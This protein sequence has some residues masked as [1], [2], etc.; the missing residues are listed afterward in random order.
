MC[1]IWIA[2]SHPRYLE[3]KGI[4]V[5]NT[6]SLKEP[7]SYNMFDLALRRLIQM[8]NI[9]YMACN[10]KRWRHSLESDFA[11]WGHFFFLKFHYIGKLV[12]T[13]N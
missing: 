12:L 11:V 4:E 10:G 2:H 7:M 9:M 5:A 8:D 13:L 6:F 3:V 1:R